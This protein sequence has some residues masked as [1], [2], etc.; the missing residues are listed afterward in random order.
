MLSGEGFGART[1]L[2]SMSCKVTRPSVNASTAI[3]FD[4]GTP[5]SIHCETAEMET[6]K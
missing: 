1:G 3:I 4:G 6:L 2:A 5:F